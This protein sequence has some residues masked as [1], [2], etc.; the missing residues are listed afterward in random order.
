MRQPTLPGAD[1]DRVITQSEALRILEAAHRALER[2][3]RPYRPATEEAYERARARWALFCEK[4]G[5]SVLPIEP[6]A[7]VT[8]L[9]S[10]TS[11]GAAPNTVRLTLSALSSL[12]KA[13]RTTP[14]DREP[15]SVRQSVIVQRWLQSWSAEHPIAP[16]K[17]APALTARQLRRVLE[18]AGEGPARNQARGAYVA[19]FARDKAL[20]LLG[21]YGALRVSEVCALTI[22]DVVASERGL[23]VT[24]RRSKT[25]QQ[26]AGAVV[27]ILPSADMGVCPVEAWRQWM[28][29]SACRFQPDDSYLN[30]VSF[31]PLFVEIGRSGELGSEQLTT[32]SA[33]RIIQRMAARAGIELVT[34]HSMRASFVTLAVTKRVP[35]PTVAKQSRHKNLNTLSRYV[36]QATLFD[37]NATQGLLDE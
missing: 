29:L 22:G 16:Q 23:S 24:I 30:R 19:R 1:Y 12:D 21:V 33:N 17:S 13:A 28:S 31:A 18:A 7:L 15:Q 25:D 14:A 3:R 6:A 26:G 36:R 27:G 2:V 11:E 5:A 32:R 4:T 20:L 9:E 37:D 34:S 10:L 8:F 35:L